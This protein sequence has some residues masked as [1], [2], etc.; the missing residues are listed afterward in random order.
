M[1]TSKIVGAL[2]FTYLSNGIFFSGIFSPFFEK[3]QKF[4]RILIFSN[5]NSTKIFFFF[6]M[7]IFFSKFSVSQF[8]KKIKK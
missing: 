8:W 4:Y 6:F 5:E 1:Q 2:Q 3:N 7:G